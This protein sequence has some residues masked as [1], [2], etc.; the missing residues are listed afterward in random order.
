MTFDQLNEFINKG[1][2]AALLSAVVILLMYIAFG[3][4]LNE[5]K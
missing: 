1:Y 3:K 4:K 5:R 2:A